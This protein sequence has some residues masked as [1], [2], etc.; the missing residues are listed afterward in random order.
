MAVKIRLTRIGTTHS[1]VYR[2][3]AVDARA[4]R[5]GACIENLGTYNPLKHTLDQWHKDRIAH[6]LSQGAQMTDAVRRLEKMLKKGTLTLV[7]HK[8]EKEEA[9]A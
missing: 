9:K 5:D 4:K 7:K 1:P 2:I 3:V 8:T 6:W